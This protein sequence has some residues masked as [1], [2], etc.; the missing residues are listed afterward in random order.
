MGPIAVDEVEIAVSHG[1]ICH[2]DENLQNNDWGMT[3]YP[4]VAGHEFESRVVRVGS[5]I[6]NFSVGDRVGAGWFS[7]TDSDGPC[8]LSGDH[9]I[10]PTSQGTV[11]G[12]HGGLLIASGSRGPRSSRSMT[13]FRWGRPVRCSAAGPRSGPRSGSSPLRPIGGGG[14]NRWSRP[15]GAQIRSILGVSR[16]GLHEPGF[17]AGGSRAIWCSRRGRR[18]GCGSDRGS[19]RDARSS[20]H[21]HEFEHRLGRVYRDARAL[22]PGSRR[23][24]GHGPHSRPGLQSHQCRNVRSP[25]RPLPAPPTPDQRSILPVD[26]GSPRRPSIFRSNRSTKPSITFSP[27]MPGT[28]WSSIFP[29]EEVLIRSW[30]R[31]DLTGRGF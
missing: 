6:R 1:G 18:I 23:G 26:T 22:R 8:A 9:T 29:P 14:R 4:F 19:G 20:D 28:A 5:S 21:H 30:G 7:H 17:E 3:V 24:R 27:E 10:S 15:S 2:S 11:V 13:A 16:H 25:D 12:R 31:V